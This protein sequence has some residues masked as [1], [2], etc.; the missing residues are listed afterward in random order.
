MSMILLTFNVNGI[1]SAIKHGLVTYLKKVNPDVVCFQ[2]IKA[3]GEIL[4]N[5][6]I[7]F[8]N[9]GYN[10]FWNPAH[11][12]GYSGTAILTKIK[13]LKI[14]NSI[15]HHIDTEGRTI[16]AEFLNAFIINGY[17][18]FSRGDL[19]RL[20]LKSSYN[21]ILFNTIIDMNFVKPV[22]LCGDL[23]VAKDWRD[24]YKEARK[25]TRAGYTE[26]ERKLFNDFL[27]EGFIDVF[28]MYN[29]EPEHYTWYSYHKDSRKMKRGWRIDYVIISNELKDKF[30][31]CSIM[32]NVTISDHVP[33]L[34]KFANFNLA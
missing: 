34:V 24:V 7:Y 33:L 30:V 15:G 28:R 23:N 13:P 5:L 26:I 20:D 16:I 14:D 8:K 4:S 22:I 2:E 11:K 9:I 3:D 1:R 25:P 32:K 6:E 17:F 27:N 21:E 19:S 10:V 18:P 29:N 31:S 12:K